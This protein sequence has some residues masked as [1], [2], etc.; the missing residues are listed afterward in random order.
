MFA[1]FE[2]GGKQYKATKGTTLK[3]EKIQEK[4]KK[5]FLIKYY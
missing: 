3:L 4:I 5:P 2:F 1:I